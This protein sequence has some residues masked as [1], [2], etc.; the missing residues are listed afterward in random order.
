MAFNLFF[1]LAGASLAFVGAYFYS[2]GGRPKD[3]MDV[4]SVRSCKIGDAREGML[5]KT[6]ASVFCDSPLPAP[7]SRIS[8]V[9]F[10]TAFFGDAFTPADSGREPERRMVR[11]VTRSVAFELRD[12]TGSIQVDLKDAAVDPLVVYSGSPDLPEMEAEF[13]PVTVNELILPSDGLLFACGFVK[14]KDD[15]YALASTDDF[16]LVVSYRPE[17]DF[18][19]ATGSSSSPFLYL[20]G[21]MCLAGAAMLVYGL[22]L[23]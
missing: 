1:T 21:V 17:K 4:S 20:G 3:L 2:K 7:N 9:Y 23:L 11:D 19:K 13:G 5:I 12:G 6:T 8:C 15:G 16:P 14:K 22:S 10:R 18:I